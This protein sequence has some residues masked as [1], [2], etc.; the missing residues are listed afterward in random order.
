MEPDARCLLIRRARRLAARYA[1]AAALVLLSAAA[2]VAQ[3][4]APTPAQPSAQTPAAEPLP[5]T[6][7]LPQRPPGPPPAVHLTLDRAIELAL[8]HNHTLLA[9][10]TTIDQNRAEETTANLR[11]NPVLSWDAQFLPIF[12]PSNFSGTYIDNTAQFDVGLSYLIE[13]GKK[14]QHRLEAAHDQ[15]N[16][17][18]ATVDDNERTLTSSVAQN[19]INVLLAE[20]NLSLAQMDLASFQQTLSIA[21]TRY[22][23]GDMGE[24]DLLKLKLQ[25]LQFQMDVSAADLGKVQA[26]AQ[27]RE[28]VGFDSVPENYDVDGE[29]AHQAVSV[30]EDDLKMLALRDRPDYH[31]AQLG[32]TAAQS[33]LSLAQANGKKD[34]SVALNYDHV[35][36][37]DVST[38]FNIQLPIFDRNQG[39]IARARFAVTQAQETQ[40]ASSEGV[41]SDVVSAYESLRT[42]DALVG[43]YAAG[44]LKEAEDSRDIAQ[45]AYER[46]A[47]S[48]LDYLD[49]ERSYRSTELGYRQALA[50]YMLALEQLRQAVGTRSLP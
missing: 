21:D 38:F 44:Y 34:L 26:L 46:G 24:G 18:V 8:E 7:V 41:L 47:A 12:Q 42:N 22:Q 40:T 16:V 45:Y 50:A 6:P 33:Q 19:F 25:L 49:A 11:P 39:E 35:A 17:T 27:L 23:D 2:A 37:N 31:A 30:S 3:A 36:L 32:V 5:P 10:R 15:T 29:L 14:R 13:R 20:A 9:Q 1:S 4:P 43:L 48:L 28:S